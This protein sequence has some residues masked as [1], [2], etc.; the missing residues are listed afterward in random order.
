MP[1]HT[2]EQGETLLALASANGLD[3]WEDIVNASENASIKDTLTDPGIV[4]PGISLFIPNKTMKQQPSAVDAKHPFQVKRPKAWLRLAMKDADGTALA[5]C[6][7]ELTVAGTT[8]SGTIA[9]GGVIEQAVP[10]DTTAGKLKVSITDTTFEEWELKI[11]WMDPISEESGVQARLA[12]LGFDFG[13]D[14]AG[15]VK[16]F[17]ARVG[18]E[19]TG[20]IDDT[21]RDKLKTY[22]DPAEDET[23]LDVAPPDDATEDEPAEET[24]A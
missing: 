1:F 10:I 14:L 24:Q 4:K 6:K 13:D 22:Y 19:V 16:A 2:V 9:A 17:Q 15:A 7:Y 3:S 8:T 11:G 18:L 12:N 21:L 20:T 23:S 5:N